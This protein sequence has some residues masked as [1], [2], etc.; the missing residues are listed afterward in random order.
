MIKFTVSVLLL[1][2][3]LTACTTPPAN[4]T[5]L[6]ISQEEVPSVW[7]RCPS[8]ESS[9]GKAHGPAMILRG[10]QAITY[11]KPGERN[12]QVSIIYEGTTT[13]RE[14]RGFDGKRASD[15]KLTIM[16]QEVDFYGSGNEV[17]EISTQPVQLTSPGGDTAWFT[18]DFSCEEHLKGKNIPAFTW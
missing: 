8:L 11:V 13:A 7:P 17:A 5:G 2:L 4:P 3:G 10:R 15:G 16:G 18:F 1:A 6:Q 12:C 9:W 14:I